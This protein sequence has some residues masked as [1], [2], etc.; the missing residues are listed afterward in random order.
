M[1]LLI[2]SLKQNEKWNFLRIY[3]SW[4]HNELTILIL[5][6]WCFCDCLSRS[7]RHLRDRFLI[8]MILHV[9]VGSSIKVNF[10]SEN[11]LNTRKLD[12]SQKNFHNRLSCG[13]SGVPFIKAKKF[14]LRVRVALFD[15]WRVSFLFPLLIPFSLLALFPFA[16]SRSL[17][18]TRQKLI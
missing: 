1:T 14:N 17:N 5:T 13:L 7:I 9:Y 16:L 8:T 4:H 11:F 6:R 2:K 18:M 12:N 10:I 3:T 15:W